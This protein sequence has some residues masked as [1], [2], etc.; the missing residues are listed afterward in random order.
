MTWRFSLL[1]ESNNCFLH[2]AKSVAFLPLV[3]IFWCIY[4][5][6]CTLLTTNPVSWV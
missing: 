6:Y 4:L 5:L 1:L 2:K 3:G